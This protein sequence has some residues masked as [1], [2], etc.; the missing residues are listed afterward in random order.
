[1]ADEG[2][3]DKARSALL[4]GIKT[5]RDG[6]RYNVINFAG[7][8]HLMERGLI[9]ADA[10]GRA[11]GDDFVK[12]LRPNGGTNINEALVAALK[13]FDKSDRPK[14]LVFMTDGLPTV[15][16]TN[17]D[18][19][20]ANL[21]SAK[22]TDVRIFPFGFGYDVN[23][24]LLDRIGSE[25][26]GI[27]DYIQPK[28]DLEVKISNF[29]EKV[30]SP[31][32][33]DIA[34]DWGT[35]NT[36]LMY[37]RQ[38]TDLFRGGQIAIIGRYRN[39]SDVQNTVITLRGKSGREVRSF[40]FGDLDFPLRSTENDFLPRLWASRRVGWLIE[41]I[42]NNGET[43][44]LRDEVTDL[45]TRYGIV[46]PYTSYLATDGTFR[47]MRDDE[48]ARMTAPAAKAMR[49]QSGAGAVQQ[50]VQQN[51][52]QSNMSIA[53]DA[54][55]DAEQQVLV[56]NSAASQYVGNKNFQNQ[57]SVWVDSDYSPVKR[58][59]EVAIKFGSDEYFDLV[60]RERGLGQYL[61]LGQQVVV[62]WNG[63]VY[64]ITD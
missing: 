39:E 44:E 12:N 16:E 41:Q 26:S 33:S 59:P 2:K 60:K 47:Q 10:K 57:N 62:V 3:M 28:E 49:A 34:I 23:T 14:M 50:S 54:K 1:M 9:P 52:M 22:T 25:N 53:L 7:E 32:L 40:A 55:K 38:V 5:L 64:R 48:K 43:K 24:T 36:D 37:P 51:A 11:R 56:Q 58:L 27:S 6:D 29:F 45:G 20:I 15:G 8:E 35:V 4:F 61:A 42:R 63:K 31:V 19:I 18:K 17:V 46:T 30:S 13:Q 21:R